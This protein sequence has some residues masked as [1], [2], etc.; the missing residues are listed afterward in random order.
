MLNHKA[1]LADAIRAVNSLKEEQERQ[2]SHIQ[3]IEQQVN[4][5]NNTLVDI[6]SSA[7]AVF[8][9]PGKLDS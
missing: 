8:E 4:E 5:L 2:W 1:T 9:D 6:L 3:L 7:G